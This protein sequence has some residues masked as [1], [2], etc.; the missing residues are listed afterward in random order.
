MVRVAQG[1]LVAGRPLVGPTA[2]TRSPL[3]QDPHNGLL[4]M[5]FGIVVF[6]GSNCDRD[7]HHIITHVLKQKAVTLWH[8]ER[9]L[10][11]L[12]CL[13][14]PGGFSY[15]DYLRPGAI[16][17]FSPI[18]SE[19]VCFAE[20]GGLVLGICNGFQVLVESGLLPGALLRNEGLKFV[21]K[22]VSLCVE[23]TDTLF[24]RLYAPSP[25]PS[26]A[27]LPA[28]QGGGRGRVIVQMP[29]AHMEG[30]YEADPETLKM[31]D[32]EGRVVFR[33]QGKNPNG[34][35][36]AIAGIC[37]RAGNVLGMMPHPERCAES[38]LGNEDGRILFES[39]L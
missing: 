38:L 35:K 2:D 24:T 30:R 36:A 9:C 37:N 33:Y 23:N 7:C 19:V 16:A 3:R 25:P 6:P 15:G 39:L 26:R 31:L 29:I 20:G 12:D 18:M 14:L 5:K 32:G 13:I 28:R 22:T 34:S 11:K 8:K 10:P 27:R 17:R 21:C 1:C 4:L